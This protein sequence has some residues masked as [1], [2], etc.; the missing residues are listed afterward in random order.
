MNEQ[1]REETADL[2][3]RFGFEQEE[4]VA[5][6]HLR[7]A[8]NLMREMWHAGVLEDMEHDER[9]GEAEARDQIVRLI[10]ELSL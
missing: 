2:R 1:V 10:Q 9:R 4:A 6:W 7:R 3:R 8:A 5:C